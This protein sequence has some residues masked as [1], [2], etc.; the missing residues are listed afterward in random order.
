MSTE[1]HGEAGA[2]YSKGGNR[3]SGEWR[4]QKESGFGRGRVG[5]LVQFLA[6]EG[7]GLVAVNAGAGSFFLGFFGGVEADEFG[8]H[9]GGVVFAAEFGVGVAKGEIDLGLFCEGFAGDFE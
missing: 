1:M 9:A 8:P 3:H 2:F 5:L 7:G 6:E 4:S